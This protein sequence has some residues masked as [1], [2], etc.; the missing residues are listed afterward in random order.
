MGI[1]AAKKY[2]CITPVVVTVTFDNK[3][4]SSVPR[5]VTEALTKA[6]DRS[7][8]LTTSPPADRNQEGFYLGAS[9]VLK[10]NSDRAIIAEMKVALGTW[11]NKR[12]FATVRDRQDGSSNVPRL[13]PLV[14]GTVDSLV[15]RMLRRQVLKEFEKRAQ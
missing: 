12:I 9:V 10:K 8:K 4:K 13:D 2:V 14:D 15:E 6:I 11:P 7:S 1:M 3:Y 5:R